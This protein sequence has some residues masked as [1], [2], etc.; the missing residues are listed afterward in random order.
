MYYWQKNKQIYQWN[1]IESTA[2]WVPIPVLLLTS[3]EILGKSFQF[4]SSIKSLWSL[5][6]HLFIFAFISIA[7][8]D[9]PKKTLVWFIIKL[10]RFCTA[11]ETINKMKRH[12]TDWEKNICKWCDQQGLNF[13]NIQ[14]APTIQWPKKTKQPTKKSGQKT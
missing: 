5:G 14:T 8:G 10:I 7:L 9:W 3:Y 4:S 11:K 2:E 12:P 6:F 1:K 13:Q